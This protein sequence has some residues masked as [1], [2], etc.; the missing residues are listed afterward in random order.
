MNRCRLLRGIFDRL[1]LV[2][3]A[4]PWLAWSGSRWVPHIKGQ[5]VS[6]IQVCNF[7]DETKAR[8]YASEHGL[9]IVG[10][11]SVDASTGVI[12]IVDK[13]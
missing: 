5:P 6:T 3:A 9:E 8:Q 4:E 7:T 10:W 11:A 12:G 1:F 2:S 13:L